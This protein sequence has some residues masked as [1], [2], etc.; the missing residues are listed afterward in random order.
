M[1]IADIIKYEGDITHEIANVKW[2]D[3][4]KYEK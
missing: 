1:A 2:A 3:G 4:Y